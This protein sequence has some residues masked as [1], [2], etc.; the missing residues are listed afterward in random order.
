MGSTERFPPK[1]RNKKESP[2][3]TLQG[4][5]GMEKNPQ[6]NPVEKEW[7]DTQLDLLQALF[8]IVYSQEMRN[9]RIKT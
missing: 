8:L 7:Q 5:E 1:T 6:N 2:R 4:P 9:L 3:K